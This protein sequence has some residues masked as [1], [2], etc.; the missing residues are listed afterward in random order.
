MD[1]RIE[2]IEIG[3]ET[4][5]VKIPKDEVYH[6]AEYNETQASKTIFLNVSDVLQQ[7]IAPN[8]IETLINL[9]GQY[10]Q[11]QQETDP[12]FTEMDD[13]NIQFLKESLKPLHINL[14]REEIFEIFEKE[15]LYMKLID[16][17]E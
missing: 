1:Y 16:L 13:S 12:N 4:Y 3:G 5:T 6:A 14:S 17:I 8:T 10:I 11:N 2:N 7:K 9:Q 15:L